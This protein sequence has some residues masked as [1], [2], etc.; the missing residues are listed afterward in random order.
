MPNNAQH[1]NAPTKPH[2]GPRFVQPIFQKITKLQ[3]ITYLKK[4]S[5]YLLEKFWEFWGIMGRYPDAF[6]TPPK[7]SSPKFPLTPPS[8]L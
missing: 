3:S 6:Q 4:A 7:L 2:L 8:P 5:Q 1:D